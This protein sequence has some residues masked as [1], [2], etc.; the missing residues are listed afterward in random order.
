MN[1]EIIKAD[2]KEIKNK[3]E[4]FLMEQLKYNF[5]TIFL[6]NYKKL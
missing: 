6:E 2:Q 5:P 1:K 3:F 4:I